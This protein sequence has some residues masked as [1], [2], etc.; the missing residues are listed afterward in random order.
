MVQINDGKKIEVYHDCNG[1]KKLPKHVVN[2]L[3]DESICK[4][5][6][7]SEF[8]VPYL[9]LNLGLTIRNLWDSMLMEQLILGVSMVGQHNTP[10]KLKVKY[11]S[12]LKYVLPRYGFPA[13]D[14]SV[15]ESFIGRHKGIPFTKQEIAYAR[16]DVEHLIDLQRMQEFI[17][18]RDNMMELALLENKTA[19]KVAAMRTKGIGFSTKL[20][21]QIA[22][23]NLEEFNRRINALP[24]GINWNSPQQVKKFFMS[25]GIFIDTY[26][27]LE[28][29]SKKANNDL[30]NKFIHA[31]SLYKDTTSYGLN[32][33]DYPD[34]DSRLRPSV[35]QIVD[36]GRMSMEDPPFQ[37]I[38]KKG[39]QRAAIVPAVGHVFVIADFTGQELGIAA[40]ASGE[41]L[42]IDAM[43]RG[44]DIHSLTASL[45]Y[46]KQWDKGTLKGCKFPSKCD[47]PVH[48]DLRDNKIKPLNFGL[49][50]GL[51]S[52]GF[53]DRTGLS[54]LDA[55]M[56]VGKYKRV[57]PRL[58][59]YLDKNARVALNTGESYSASPYKRRRVLIETQEW[60]IKNQGKNN[61]IQAAGADMLKLA[62]ISI[63]DKY[64]IVIFYHD[65]IGAEVKKSEA[66][67]ALKVVKGVMSETADYITGI[68]GLIKADPRIATNFMKT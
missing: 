21:R 10:E 66:K 33:L 25:K 56:L 38:P 62:T 3:A 35:N 27:N 51:S 49:L 40:A 48:K 31:R 65:E 64:P 32:W 54:K 7:R 67:T 45:I 5:V 18:T 11:S 29:I 2:L 43:L 4:I 16:Q 52:W 24:G 37:T 68:K 6:H 42:W 53:A 8:D 9:Q 19:E 41:T 44:D 17:L 1:L 39:L 30:L 20:W 15:R 60:R 57:V 61:P 26:D 36:T 59:R 13:P 58:M 14:K 46:A 22:I 28:K 23:K 63:P 50:Y 34:A 47:C 55:Q 12:S